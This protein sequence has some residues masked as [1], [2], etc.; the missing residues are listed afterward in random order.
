MP[1]TSDIA[2]TKSQ[3]R[4]DSNNSQRF[5]MSLNLSRKHTARPASQIRSNSSLSGTALNSSTFL[6]RVELK[7]RQ[8]NA[9]Y[10]TNSVSKY[11]RAISLLVSMLM[12]QGLPNDEEARGIRLLL[13][14]FILGSVMNAVI[15]LDGVN[16]CCDK[17]LGSPA[18]I[19]K[20][21]KHRLILV[22]RVSLS[23]VLLFNVQQRVPW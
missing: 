22:H 4:L 19:R 13:I 14:I 12:L 17:V 11:I 3:S 16:R 8:A 7:I 1:I 10:A 5:G 23:A 15:L 18:T 20:R 6:E 21:V 9:W 2:A